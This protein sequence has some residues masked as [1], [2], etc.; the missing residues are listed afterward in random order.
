MKVEFNDGTTTY[1]G[2][3]SEAFKVLPDGKYSGIA[4]LGA[5]QVQANIIVRT[6]EGIRYSFAQVWR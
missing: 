5:L 2:D 3:D 1:S 4:D 6:V